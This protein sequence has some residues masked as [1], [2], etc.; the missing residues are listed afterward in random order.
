M[1]E[2][3]K[4]LVYKYQDGRVLDLSDKYVVSNYGTFKNIKTGYTL[5]TGLKVS[6]KGKIENRYATVGIGGR[7]LRVHRAV[8]STFVEGY[9]PGLEIDHIDGD[10][11]NNKADNFRWLTK[12]EHMAI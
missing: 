9:A 8:A 12:A 10:I 1:K 4:P 11:Y 3:F 5:T 7:V 6:P 2:L